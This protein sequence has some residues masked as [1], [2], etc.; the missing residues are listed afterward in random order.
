MASLGDKHKQEFKKSIKDF[1]DQ[2]VNDSSNTSAYLGLAETNVILYI[3][4]FTSREETL[5]EA[6]SALAA[7]QQFDQES[8]EYHRVSGMLNFLDR[9]WKKAEIDF[10]SSINTNP[11]NLNA[12]HWYSLFLYAVMEDVEGALAQHDTI[13]AMDPNEDYLIGRGSLYY[14]MQDH[15]ELKRLMLKDTE[16][17]PETPW[18][19]DWLGMAYNG[20]KEHD[21]AIKT[22]L[23]AFELSDGTVEVGGGLGH[24]LGEAGETELAKQM[25]DF[26]TEQ[27]KSNYLPPCQRAFIH[28]SI[29]ENE[30]AIE[31]LEQAFEEKSWFLIFMKIEHWYDPLRSDPR[32][33]R[34]IKKFNYPKV[35][36]VH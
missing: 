17:H 29:G 25:A 2:I 1:K 15:E 14:F 10:L 26:Y 8:S 22:Y 3:F 28:V 30:K 24:A 23:K 31:L 20:L 7:M 11:K 12:R 4:G 36:D 32:F 6:K 27:S 21:N 18:G 9:K 33:Q 19:F 35:T 16:M 13:K 5:P 34:L